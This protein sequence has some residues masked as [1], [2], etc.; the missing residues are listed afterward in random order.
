MGKFTGHT[1]TSD[2][3]LGSAKIERSLRFTRVDS[4]Y[5]TRTVGTTGN[6]RTWTV[7]FWAKFND[8][9]ASNNQRIWSNESGSGNGSILKIEMYGGTDE[10]RQIGF[11]DNNHAGS[12]IRFTTE[13][14]FRDNA[15]YHIMMAVDT[16]QATDTNRVKIYVNGD[17]LSNWLSGSEHNHPPNQNYDTIVNQSGEVNSWGRSFAFSSSTANYFDGYLTEI[18]FIDGQQLSPTDV[19]FTD[20][21]TGIWMPKRYEGTYGTNGYRLDFLDNS[22]TTAL[23]I[24]KSPNGNDFTV[25]NFSVAANL[26]NDSMPDTPTNNFCTLNPLNATSSFN[27][28]SNDGLL[29]FDQS[30]NDQAITGTFFVT[31]GKWYWEVYKNAS[32]NPE[33]G[34]DAQVTFSQR[35]AGGSGYTGVTTKVAFI[36]NNGEMRKGADNSSHTFTGGSAQ[37]GAGWIRIACDMDNKKIWF[38]DTSGNYFNS[39]DPATGTNEAFDFSSVEVANGWSPLIYMGTGSGHNC[40][41]NFGQLDLNNFSSNIPTGFKTLCSR[42]LV[43]DASQIVRPQKHFEALIYTGTATGSGTQTISD[44]E[45]APDFVWIKSRAIG[46][47]HLLVDT[48][49][50]ASKGLLTE[51]TDAEE[52][53]NGY[54]MVTAFGSNGFTMTRGSTDGGKC[55]ENTQTYVAWCWKAGGNS[56]TYN[57]DGKGYATAAAAGLDGGTI[58]PTGSSINTKSGFSIITYTG[59]GSAGATVAH[60]LGKKP[61]WIIIKRRDAVDNWMVYHKKANVGVSPEDYYAEL[62]SNSADINS[63]VMLND[64]APTSTLITLGSDNS[65][66]GN[67]ATY[68]MYCWSEIPGFSKFGTY[69]ANGNGHGPYVS[70]GFRPAWVLIKNISL[71]Q[72]WVLID[73]KRETYN[74]AY[75]SLGPSTSAADYESKGNNGIDFLADGFKIRGHG[76]GDNNYSSSY[77]NHIY[78]AFA[79]APSITPFDTF[80]NA[81]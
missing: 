78:M 22:S 48:V 49:R 10:A 13:R 58:D 9:T 74:E 47:S 2:S 6:R 51:A 43:P 27:F 32:Q 3:A 17:Q 35:S 56:N 71:G 54:G 38:S 37:T 63:T 4:A 65:V 69:K 26:S 45:F 60:G 14:G 72:P 76:S 18:N 73:N 7:S 55:C 8:P 59:N 61:A 24:D 46:Y 23:G 20:P 28:G 33:L 25:N 36:T 57:I 16:T 1:I 42:N 50:G 66:N 11:I 31:S 5:I 21:V 12:G 62:N 15:W 41:V 53:S 70:L 75:T 64:T 30:A 34:I 67:T 80:P 39:G 44:L 29:V 52:T 68:V 19:G 79:E 40:Y 81:R 77:P